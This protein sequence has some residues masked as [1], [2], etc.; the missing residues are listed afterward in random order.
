ME[1]TPG[2]SGWEE[3]CTFLSKDVPPGPFPNVPDEQFFV[4]VHIFY[5][6]RAVKLAAG[7]VALAAA[8]VI[9]FSAAAWYLDCFTA[10][11]R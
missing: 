3:L 9:C 5:L 8:P 2:K 10:F 4:G 7:K 11:R 1:F 6:I